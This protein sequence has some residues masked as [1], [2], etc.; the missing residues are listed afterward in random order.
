MHVVKENDLTEIV[1]H[2]TCLHFGP[3]VLG[4]AL[5]ELACRKHLEPCNHLVLLHLVEGYQ[6][7]KAW[8]VLL[9]TPQFPLPDHWRAY[10][11]QLLLKKREAKLLLFHAVRLLL[12]TL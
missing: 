3:Y 9:A 4:L 6:A 11:H 8:Y 5:A 2:L 1:P 12:L 10:V 7:W